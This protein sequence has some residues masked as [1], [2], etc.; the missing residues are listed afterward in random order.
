MSSPLS[1]AGRVVIVT[2]AGAGM[3]RSHARVLAARG[4]RVVVNDIRSAAAVVDEIRAAGGE[5]LAD[6]N[7]ISTPEGAPRLIE[8]ALGH[9]GA[10]DAVVNNAGIPCGDPFP[11]VTWER[12]DQVQK[13]NAYGAYFVTQHAWPHLIASGSGRVVMIASKAAAIGAPH[14]SAYGASKGAILAM[15]RQIAAEGAAH[16]IGVNA[17][18][19]SAITQMSVRPHPLSARMAQ[20]LGVDPADRAMLAERSAAVV[21]TVVAWLCHPDCG[22]NGE[23]I[24]AVGGQTS[25]LTFAMASGIA[26]GDLTVETVRDRFDEI[27]DMDGASILPTLFMPSTQTAD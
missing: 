14:L 1:F 2:G 23:F 25:R 7:D 11:E 6:E 16:G 21:S 17:V 4:A 9:F 22:S 15:T 8:S 18:T 26:D 12:F 3:G 13:V 27:L 10:I 20:W 24:D 5:A 19:P